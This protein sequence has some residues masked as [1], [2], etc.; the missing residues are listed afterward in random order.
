MAFKQK[1]SKKYR[2]H[3]TTYV[4]HKTLPNLCHVGHQPIVFVYSE[5]DQINVFQFRAGT[6]QCSLQSPPRIHQLSP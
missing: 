3:T 4:I 5:T 2:L 6:T 1:T